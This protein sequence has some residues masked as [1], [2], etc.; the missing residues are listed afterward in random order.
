M[1]ALSFRSTSFDGVL[2]NDAPGYIFASRRQRKSLHAIPGTNKQ[3]IQLGGFDNYILTIRAWREGDSDM[4]ATFEAL[5]DGVTGTLSGLPKSGTT[6][7]ITDLLLI[8][9]GPV[10]GDNHH[11]YYGDDERDEVMLYFMKQG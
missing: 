5:V 4:R 9:V 3:V 10:S 2:E 11:G 7:S 1:A 6:Y 8:D